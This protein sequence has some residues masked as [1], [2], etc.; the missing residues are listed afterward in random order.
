MKPLDID[1]KFIVNTEFISIFFPDWIQAKRNKKHEWLFYKEYYSI[2][3]GVGFLASDT[4][5]NLKRVYIL[6]PY[7]YLQLDIYE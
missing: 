2:D 1:Q 3:V 7:K 5:L 6:L 4:F